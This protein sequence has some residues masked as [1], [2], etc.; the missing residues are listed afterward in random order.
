[1][2]K[3]SIVLNTN[4]LCEDKFI[5]LECCVMKTRKSLVARKTRTQA[6]DLRITSTDAD[7]AKLVKIASAPTTF[8]LV[9]WIL[10]I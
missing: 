8:L 2:R 5:F 6:H 7:T 9:I 4:A 1:M 10:R 3:I